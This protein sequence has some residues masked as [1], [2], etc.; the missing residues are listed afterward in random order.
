M[1]EHHL[2]PLAWI[3]ASNGG[4]GGC[5]VRP[6]TCSLRTIGWHP[7]D[8]ASGSDK[9]QTQEP[10]RRNPIDT[11]QAPASRARKVALHAASEPISSLDAT[12]I[13]HA[14]RFLRL[15]PASLPRRHARDVRLISSHCANQQ[16]RRGRC[17]MHVCSPRRV[18]HSP[19][20]GG[21]TG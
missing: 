12:S 19:T 2:V 21:Q 1:R 15:S 6:L 10:Q 3:E 18:A 7:C 16:P 17:C 14:L 8:A 5:R 11:R 4:A 20:A 9:K 13:M